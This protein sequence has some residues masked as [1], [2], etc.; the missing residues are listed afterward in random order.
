[1]ETISQPWL[2][3]AGLGPDVPHP[4]TSSTHPVNSKGLPALV[5]LERSPTFPRTFGDASSLVPRGIHGPKMEKRQD[6]PCGWGISWEKC[7]KY[8]GNIWWFMGNIWEIYG[9]G[10]LFPLFYCGASHL[11]CGWKK[12]TSILYL[13]CPHHMF[14]WVVWTYPKKKWLW[15]QKKL[16]KMVLSE[17]SVPPKFIVCSIC[18]MKIRWSQM[19]NW[20]YPHFQTTLISKTPSSVWKSSDCLHLSA[21]NRSRLSSPMLFH[22]VEVS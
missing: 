13:H 21:S 1:M 6:G 2:P 4:S 5:A 20:G 15:E 14:C 10:M 19:T 8:M 18:S 7:G 16:K 17:N 11:A 3:Q 22:V 12:M 9:N